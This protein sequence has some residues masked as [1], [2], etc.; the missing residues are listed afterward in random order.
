MYCQKLLSAFSSLSTF[1]NTIFP[2]LL[3]AL[4]ISSFIWY[5]LPKTASTVIHSCSPSCPYYGLCMVLFMLL[6]FPSCSR[7]FYNVNVISLFLPLS[8]LFSIFFLQIDFSPLIFAISCPYFACL[9]L[10]FNFFCTIY[11]S[12]L[13]FDSITWNAY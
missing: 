13:L 5:G 1:Q 3:P 6:F 12:I 9:L 2:F 7:L 4:H 11:D 10:P 8:C